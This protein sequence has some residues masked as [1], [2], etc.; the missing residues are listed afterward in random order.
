MA[1]LESRLSA[2]LTVQLASLKPLAPGRRKAIKDTSGFHSHSP[3]QRMKQKE[4]VGMEPLL[5][6]DLRRAW[7]LDFDLSH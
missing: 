6:W 5:C 2:F 7:K 3:T 4:A 1:G